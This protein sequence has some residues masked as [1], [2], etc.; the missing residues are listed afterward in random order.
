MASLAA[1][2]A[3]ALEDKQYD[4]AIERYTQ[5]LAQLPEAAPY[6]IG[7][8]TAYQR[9][10]PPELEAALKDAEIAVKLAHKRAKRELIAEA[11]LR[12]AIAL[13]SLG[14]YKDSE[15]VLEFS[16]KFKADDKTGALWSSKVANKLKQSPDATAES[17]AKE[18]PEVEVN[19]GAP[20]ASKGSEKSTETSPTTTTSAERHKPKLEQI[21]HDWYEDSDYVYVTLLAKGIPKD[22]AIVEIEERSLSISIPTQNHSTYQQTFDPLRGA[23]DP[24]KS[25]YNITAYKLEIK[26]KKANPFKWSKLEAPEGEAQPAKTSTAEPKPQASTKQAAAAGPSYP[27]SSRSG[28]KNWDKLADDLTTKVGDGDEV[29]ED[30]GDPA[31]AFFKKLYKDADPDTRRA[32]MKSYQESNGTALS[33][34]WKEVSK[35]PVETSPPDGMIAK[36]WE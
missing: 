11:Q 29:E 20:I 32:M 33:T 5:A 12:R 26:L 7:R 17:D 9:K 31:A 22:E 13:F 36:K 4:L 35:A 34:N 27:S 25:S 15:R 23:V 18:I 14:R 2:A 8:C 21:R 3:Q 1:S 16:K 6:Y 30:D 24:Q 28:P 19:T 10:S